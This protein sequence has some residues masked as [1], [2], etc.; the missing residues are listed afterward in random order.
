MNTILWWISMGLLVAGLLVSAAPRAWRWTSDA[1][2]MTAMALLA[3]DVIVTPGIPTSMTVTL[4]SLCA[5]VL[6][7]SAMHLVRFTIKERKR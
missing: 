3:V 1:I 6:V 5:G 4:V 2:Y 7:L